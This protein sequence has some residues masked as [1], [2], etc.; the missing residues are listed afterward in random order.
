MIWFSLILSNRSDAVMH[1]QAKT[2][3]RTVL[4]TRIYKPHG[5]FFTFETGMCL[6]R[7]AELGSHVG[8]D[9]DLKITWL[10]KEPHCRIGLMHFVVFFFSRY[11]LDQR[12][13]QLCT[14]TDILKFCLFFVWIFCQ[15]SSKSWGHL[16]RSKW[17]I[18]TISISGAL[19][20]NTHCY[21]LF[22]SYLIC[23][24]EYHHSI[25]MCIILVYLNGHQ[26]TLSCV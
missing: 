4:S 3:P 13:G 14:P 9:C 21:I 26:P 17:C 19:A 11:S 23:I 6:C 24:T 10:L 5:F 7:M 2:Y 22:F 18:C 12:G 1:M 20:P 8:F 16:Y 25:S 15:Q